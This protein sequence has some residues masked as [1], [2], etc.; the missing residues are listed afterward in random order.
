MSSWN[1]Q[2]AR[3]KLP[4]PAGQRRG[5]VKAIC[6]ITCVCLTGQDD[7]VQPLSRVLF[8]PYQGDPSSYNC[9][10]LPGYIAYVPKHSKTIN[11]AA[12]Q[13]ML[14]RVQKCTRN[15]LYRR[16][17]ENKHT[18]QRYKKTYQLKYLE[19]GWIS[20]KLGISTSVTSQG[21]KHVIISCHCLP[22][23]YFL[24]FGSTCV[25]GCLFLFVTYVG[26]IRFYF[27]LEACER[28]KNH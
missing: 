18:K 8:Q 4:H 13:I 10:F 26:Q 5:S 25:S 2:G 19:R 11:T 9:I 21:G 16:E 24:Y 27:M 6:T 22:L 17:H 1:D 12:S 20:T 23:S 14:S 7:L 3:L 15:N 28:R